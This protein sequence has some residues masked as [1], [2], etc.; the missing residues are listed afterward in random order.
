MILE[1]PFWPSLIALLVGALSG[2]GL[3][4][5][6]SWVFCLA[7]GFAAAQMLGWMALS[8]LVPAR[9]DE[10]WGTVL[11]GSFL[12][13]LMIVVPYT[14]IGA[15]VSSAIIALTNSLIR[16]KPNNS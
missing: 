5:S 15:I 7:L 12:V 10:P 4:K 16:K 3:L 14:T 11:W 1:S 6:R 13:A 2:L 8:V 9:Q